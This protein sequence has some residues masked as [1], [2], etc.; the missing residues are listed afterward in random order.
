MPFVRFR[1]ELMV[2]SVLDQ[3]KDIEKIY[4][5]LGLIAYNILAVPVAG[6]GCERVFSIAKWLKSDHKFYYPNTFHALMIIN[7][8]NN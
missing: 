7:Y 8:Y 3:W 1:F 5:V 2:I 6:I 4:P